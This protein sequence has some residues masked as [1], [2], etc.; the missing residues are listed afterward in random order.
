MCCFLEINYTAKLIPE[1]PQK[2]SIDANHF[3]LT[4]CDPVFGSSN[5]LPHSQNAFVLPLVNALRTAFS[6]SCAVFCTLG[7]ETRE[8]DIGYTLGIRRARHYFYLYDPHSRDSEGLACPNGR[9]VMIEFRTVIGLGLYFERLCMSL[10]LNHVYAELNPCVM[11]QEIEGSNIMLDTGGRFE[12]LT[13]QNQCNIDNTYHMQNSAPAMK[14]KTESHK[15]NQSGNNKRKSSNTSNVQ[16]NNQNPESVVNN[17]DDTTSNNQQEKEAVE[18]KS[19]DVNSKECQQKIN[20]FHQSVANGPTITCEVCN[21]LWYKHSVSEISKNLHPYAAKLLTMNTNV[22][23]II[24]C[25]TCKTYIKRNKT[26][27]VSIFNIGSFP[28]MPESLKGLNEGEWRLL[29]PR[30]PF[31]KIYEASKGRQFKL[32]GNVVNVPSD[33]TTTLSM[34]PRTLAQDETIKLQLKRRLEYKHSYLSAN[35]RP[36]LQ[37]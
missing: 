25:N 20:K 11:T 7:D 34:L 17:N 22:D 37:T 13:I 32:R 21:Q 10:G 28:C 27:P 16:S 1:L 14:R 31:M 8:N 36:P 3:K 9:S 23:S 18:R 5:V 12:I 2:I 29:S 33:V 6:D 24:I 35:I 15:S 26:P 19:T 4:F 30:L